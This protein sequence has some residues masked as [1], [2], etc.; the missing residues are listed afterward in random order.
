MPQFIER[1]PVYANAINQFVSDQ[2]VK[3]EQDAAAATAKR[4]K[5]QKNIAL[6][7]GAGAGAIGG[8][9]LAPA[10]GLAGAA[11]APGFGTV[12]APGVGAATSTAL[13]TGGVLSG[14]GAVTAGL[15]GA[16]IGA[17]I[18]GNLQEGDYGAALNTA[19]TTAGGLNQAYQNQKLYGFQPTKEDRAA[20]QHLAIKAGTSLGDLE[21]KA[22]QGHGTVA[23]QLGYAQQ[24][25]DANAVQQQYLHS[26]ATTLG[27]G[28]ALDA[29]GAE[30]DGLDGQ[31]YES[32]PD[33]GAIADVQKQA[34][35]IQSSLA[36][37][38][39][40]RAEASRMAVPVAQR[41]AQAKVG[42][43][44]RKTQPIV[45]DN[46]DGTT[47]EVPYGSD[48]D[49]EGTHYF[50]KS[51]DKQGRPVY[52]TKT[53]EAKKFNPPE[54]ASPDVL[55]KYTEG[56]LLK[57]NIGPAEADQYYI[58]PKDGSIQQKKQ[59]KDGGGTPT[60]FSFKEYHDAVNAKI[61]DANG[62]ERT[63]TPEEAQKY[64]MDAAN[65]LNAVNQSLKLA[66]TVKA[67]DGQFD[68]MLE[69][70]PSGQ[71]SQDDVRQIAADGMKAF[72]PD[73]SKWPG[74]LGDK[75]K[76]LAAA[77]KPEA[78]GGGTSDSTEPK[79]SARVKQLQKQTQEQTAKAQESAQKLQQAAITE[80]QNVPQSRLWKMAADHNAKA[81]P[82]DDIQLIN[83][84]GNIV[85]VKGSSLTP[86][87]VQLYRRNGFRMPGLE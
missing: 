47:R 54:N 44:Q 11:A 10:L 59:E 32:V 43:K 6:G 12:L 5:H 73:P 35:Q 24:A 68:Q 22:R 9:V 63:R 28:D 18:A 82:D 13:G 84:T 75:L 20:L 23:Q 33:A 30:I 19:A 62:N 27:H 21:N 56:Y 79:M 14:I 38:H 50:V 41:L 17:N 78:T 58:D 61:T 29:L 3:A 40:T 46:G 2:R 71:V 37:G 25:D 80:Q 76:H 66:P 16:N 60:H 36:A 74:G 86:E 72:G 42:N 52:A 51:Y 34:G 8:L 49:H 53:I 67:F 65:G 45:L 1:Q 69:A 4:K 83:S 77:T 48:Y 39:I 87:Q 64:L 15:A 55:K 85:Q 81:G 70:A 31:G 57:H 26:A 7:I